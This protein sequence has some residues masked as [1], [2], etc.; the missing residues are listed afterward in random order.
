[1]GKQIEEVWSQCRLELQCLRFEIV[2]RSACS[3]EKVYWAC[4]KAFQFFWIVTE[5]EGIVCGKVEVIH[6]RLTRRLATDFALKLESL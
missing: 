3:I 4:P 1:L 2:V 5:L 6:R